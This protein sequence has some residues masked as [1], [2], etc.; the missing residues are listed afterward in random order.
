[1]Q[2]DHIRGEIERMRAQVGRQR[3][4]ILAL[5]HA[6]IS[7]TSAEV[8]LQRMLDKIDNLCIERDRL[9][10]ELPKLKSKVLGGRNW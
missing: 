2:L 8:L 10:K 3:R 1:M 6:G 9:K 4:E 7:T 5:Q